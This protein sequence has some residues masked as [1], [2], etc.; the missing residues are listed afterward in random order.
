M[1]KLTK[2]IATIGPSSDSPEKIEELINLGV[3]IYR[4][5]FKHSDVQWHKERIERVKAI[6]KK[7]DKNIATL[8]DLQGPE[9][10]AYLSSEKLEI[11][12]DE[13]I[14]VTKDSVK[15]SQKSL[16]FNPDGVVDVLN[17]GQRL[18]ADDGHFVFTVIKKGQETYLKSQTEG[19]LLNK[20]TINVRN[21]EYDFPVL[22]QNDEIGIKLAKELEIDFVALSFVR[23]GEDIEKLRAELKKLNSTARIVSKIETFK[24]TQNID[25]IITKSDAIMIARGDMGVELSLEE[26]P[27][28]QK[29]IIRKCVARGVPVITATQM[30]ETMTNSKIPTRAEVSDVSNAVYDFTDGVMLSGE[31]A[32][33]AHPDEVV[34][35]MAR[36]VKFSE[37]KNRVHDIRNIIDYELKDNSEMVV[38]SA[39]NLYKSLKNMDKQIKGFIVF[40]HSGKTARMLS[41]YRSHVPIFAFCPDESVMRGLCLNYGVDAVLQ[42]EIK[43]KDEVV[44]E[45]IRDAINYLK[46]EGQCEENDTFIVLHGDY[47]TSEQG[48]STIRLITV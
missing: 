14:L 38:D 24:A 8:I 48:T 43:V 6:S 40:T 39:F 12:K 17:D 16:Y 7:L 3:N 34:K 41:R 19:I 45:E 29:E 35:L 46:E 37:E 4:F 44:K 20:K 42:R 2:I 21:L 13:E 32:M 47:W 18:V 1:D 5:N 26:V 11:S 10:R 9:I 33:G 25:E 28:Y 31:T 23:S 36:V 22:T 15:T 30:L 27:F